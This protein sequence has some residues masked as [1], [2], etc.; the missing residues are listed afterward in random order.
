MHAP[1]PSLRHRR[2]FYINPLN[3]CFCGCLWRMITPIGVSDNTWGCLCGCHGFL[4]FLCGLNGTFCATGFSFCSVYSTSINI[5]IV[6]TVWAS[7]SPKPPIINANA[8][9]DSTLV[10]LVSLSLVSM[11]C[12]S[13]RYA[14]DSGGM[15]V[16]TIG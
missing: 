3:K 4:P 5:S 15:V 12:Y 2:D 11:P 1:E 10:S 9:E 14:L 13:L 7:A 6:T 8:S 16:F